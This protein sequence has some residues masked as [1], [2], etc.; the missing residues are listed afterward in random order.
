[1]NAQAVVA[2]ASHALSAVAA[3][4]AANARA[5]AAALAKI[6]VSGP[7][8]RASRNETHALTE[9]TAWQPIRG[10][11]VPGSA[12]SRARAVLAAKNPL[13]VDRAAVRP[14]VV[15]VSVAVRSAD[16]KPEFCGHFAVDSP[17]HSA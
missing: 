3:A 9:T 1:M 14:V 2:S 8:V 11:V 5:A 4:G 17:G 16:K 15:R 13:A 12:S 6:A 10:R 7:S